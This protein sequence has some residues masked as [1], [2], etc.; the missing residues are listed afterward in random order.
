M[1]WKEIVGPGIEIDEFGEVR[2]VTHAEAIEYLMGGLREAYRRI[3]RQGREIGALS[4]RLMD[5]EGVPAALAHMEPSQ[6]DTVGDAADLIRTPRLTDRF[7]ITGKTVGDAAK[8]PALADIKDAVGKILDRE[9]PQVPT[10]GHPSKFSTVEGGL[11]I[12][13]ES[14]DGE[15]LT[16]SDIHDA[17]WYA[18]AAT[19]N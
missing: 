19:V 18:L 14:R 12:E 13:V 9:R 6:D 8:P 3:E 11:R 17:L 16:A 5:V 4:K 10:P 15:P 7:L 2:E 1:G